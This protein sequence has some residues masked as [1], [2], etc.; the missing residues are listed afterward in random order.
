M[1]CLEGLQ[2]KAYFLKKTRCISTNHKTSGT[3]SFGQAMTKA[4]MF[5]HHAQQQI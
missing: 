2:E 3:M 1:A 4:E 5:G